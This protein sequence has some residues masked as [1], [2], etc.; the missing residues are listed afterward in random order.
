MTDEKIVE[1]YFKRDE[2]AIAQTSQKYSAYIRTV[3]Y[4]ILNSAQDA[5]ECENDTYLRTWSAI[6][7]H[8]PAV[9]RTFLAKIAR[10]LAL[11]MWEKKSAQK[12]GEN[13]TELLSELEECSCGIRSPQPDIEQQADNAELARVLNDF[14]R[15]L[16]REQRVVFVRRYWYA[17]SISAIAERC[18]MSESKVKSMLMRTRNKLKQRLES[19]DIPL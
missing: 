11:N 13:V 7:P 1:L 6:P 12:R 4:N 8:R 19:E 16:G 10:N 2:T 9:L 14:V 3:A 15:N 18:G 5:D 17:D